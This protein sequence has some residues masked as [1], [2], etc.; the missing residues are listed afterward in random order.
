MYAGHVQP[1]L[2]QSS[3]PIS[4]LQI[5]RGDLLASPIW[6]CLPFYSDLVGFQFESTLF[7]METIVCPTICTK[8]IIYSDRVGSHFEL[9]AA[10]PYWF[11]PGLIPNPSTPT[12][13][14]PPP[15]HT[16]PRPHP[17]P[18]SRTHSL[19]PLHT[20]TPASPPPP[21]NPDHTRSTPSTH[22]PPPPLNPDHTRSTPYTHQPLT[23]LPSTPTTPAPPLHTPTPSPLNPDHTRSTPYT[24][25]HKIIPCKPVWVVPPSVSRTWGCLSPASLNSLSTQRSCRGFAIRGFVWCSPGQVGCGDNVCYCKANLSL[26]NTPQIKLIVCDMND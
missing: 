16:N 23:P 26:E 3:T 9:Q 1:I 12:T 13:P 4:K 6:P 15:T 25:T 19:N 11:I 22:Q 18:Q 5:L 21:L 20:P 10:H 14:A 8:S 17:S 7:N 24:N 2:M